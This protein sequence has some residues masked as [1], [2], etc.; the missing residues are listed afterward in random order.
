MLLQKTLS[1]IECDPNL[2][3]RGFTPL[4]L[5]CMQDGQ[6][7]PELLKIKLTELPCFILLLDFRKM[8]TDS[9]CDFEACNDLCLFLFDCDNECLSALV[10][11]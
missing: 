11:H 3:K 4:V 9:F 8:L 10:L 7:A 6:I 5:Y 1:L 2:V